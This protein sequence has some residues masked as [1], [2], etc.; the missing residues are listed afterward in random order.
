MPGTAIS[1]AEDFFNTLSSGRAFEFKGVWLETFH[2]RTLSGMMAEMRDMRHSNPVKTL[3][4]DADNFRG[5]GAMAL[6]FQGKEGFVLGYS[7][8]NNAVHKQVMAAYATHIQI[9]VNKN[10]QWLQQACKGIDFNPLQRDGVVR[11]QTLYPA[12]IMNYILGGSNVNIKRNRKEFVDTFYGLLYGG[13]EQASAALQHNYERK[14]ASNILM[15]LVHYAGPQI[16]RKTRPDGTI[17]EN[18]IKPFSDI[19]DERKNPMVSMMLHAGIARMSEVEFRRALSLLGHEGVRSSKPGATYN[20]EAFSDWGAGDDWDFAVGNEQDTNAAKQFKSAFAIAKIPPEWLQNSKDEPGPYFFEHDGNIIKSSNENEENDRT[21][22]KVKQLHRHLRPFM[23]NA[24]VAIAKAQSRRDNHGVKE[25]TKKWAW[26][27]EHSGGATS[28]LLAMDEKYKITATFD[29]YSSLLEQMFTSFTLRTLASSHFDNADK[30][31]E[32]SQKNDLKINSE[33]VLTAVRRQLDANA[34]DFTSPTKTAIKD[35]LLKDN[36]AF[37]DTVH[38]NDRLHKKHST[39][40]K[41]MN[42][43]SSQ[44]LSWKPL[45]ASPF[46]HEYEGEKL[47]ASVITTRKDLLEEGREMSHCVFSY[48]TRCFN[49]DSVILSI[50][51]DNGDRVATMEIAKDEYYEE[52]YE[53]DARLIAPIEYQVEQCFSHRNNPASDA[54]WSLAN[55]LVDAVN[56]RKIDVEHNISLDQKS[57]ALLDKI[58][59]NPLR[60]GD[61]LADYPYNSDAAYF[62]KEAISAHLPKGKT[63]MG[64]FDERAGCFDTIFEQSDFKKE[65]EQIESLQQHYYVSVEE[66]LSLKTQLQAPDIETLSAQITAMAALHQ[67]IEVAREPLRKEGLELAQQATMLIKDVTLSTASGEETPRQVARYDVA[68]LKTY[69]ESDGSISSFLRSCPVSIDD[70]FVP[71][72]EP[73]PTETIAP[74]NRRVIR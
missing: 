13:V 57:I 4:F 31:V 56:D 10:E 33:R 63:M 9:L 52:D 46:K 20:R 6:R 39:M 21:A 35:W 55:T 60:D 17:E 64:Y 30:L 34:S 2:R 70:T 8:E 74:E 24:G 29:D 27:S 28:A 51:N 7:F 25:I 69:L 73:I 71:V 67:V 38:L 72:P 3:L 14:F 58:K 54:A 59:E 23:V 66:L 22:F 32:L 50:T 40:L 45:I 43:H 42:Q 53:E 61:V 15:D 47:T 12:V 41:A 19:V 11:D 36:Y 26:L 5:G 48:L 37:R 65:M 49:G 62:F 16:E 44:D 68:K 1:S 18:V